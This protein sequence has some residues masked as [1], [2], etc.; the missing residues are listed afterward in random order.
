[1]RNVDG[2]V[3]WTKIAYPKGREY[4]IPSIYPLFGP[5]AD[6]DR[7]YCSI[8]G[9][10][11]VVWGSLRDAERVI[12]I[13][14]RNIGRF[15]EVCVR[16][17]HMDVAETREEAEALKDFK[18]FAILSQSAPIG[19][20]VDY[21]IWGEVM[22]RKGNPVM[23]FGTLR[24]SQMKF[25]NYKVIRDFEHAMYLR[26]EIRRQGDNLPALLTRFDLRRV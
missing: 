25:S 23:H 3:L 1:M 17:L 13:V 10:G 14:K 26:G 7:A 11:Q 16:H 4:T 12:P 9:N 5:S 20:F 21:S 18:E 8:E 24:T 6:K 19:N 22:I 15:T 2:F